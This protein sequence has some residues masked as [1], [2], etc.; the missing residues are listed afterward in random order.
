MKLLLDTHIAIWTALDPDRLTMDERRM[1]EQA[2]APLVLS[3]VTVWEARLKWHSFHVSGSRKGPVEPASLLAFAKAMRW[4]MLPLS[5]WHA[6]ARLA[7]S[8]DHKDPFD[9]LLLVQAQ[10]EGLRLLTRDTKLSG[11]PLA[12]A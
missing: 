4:E 3:A 2:E 1:M 12:A 9:E 5:P 10:E 6:V 8:L 7:H 11:H